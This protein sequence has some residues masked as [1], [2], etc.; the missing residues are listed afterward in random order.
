MSVAY[1]VP[2]SSTQSRVRWS[3]VIILVV[4]AS[5]WRDAAEVLAVAVSAATVMSFVVG[6]S[7]LKRR[8]AQAH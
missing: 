7:T 8:S 1:C 5:V 2:L 4:I 3:L 6:D